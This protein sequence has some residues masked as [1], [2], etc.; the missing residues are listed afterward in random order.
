MVPDPY[1][2]LSVLEPKQSTA[3]T[4]RGE[5]RVDFVNLPIQCT[6]RIYS[7]SGKLVKIIEHEGFRDNGREAWDLT[8]RDGLEV[9]YGVYFFHIDAPG[10]GQKLGKF[11]IIK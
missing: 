6:I 4:G 10:I 7:V 8:S 9:A 11:A 5:R 1:V 2:A 3:L